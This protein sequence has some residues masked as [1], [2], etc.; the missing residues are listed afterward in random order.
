[1]PGRFPCGEIYGKRRRF[2]AVSEYSS[3]A[4]HERDIDDD[5]ARIPE[6]SVVAARRVARALIEPHLHVGEQLI[7]TRPHGEGGARRLPIASP[8]D[9]NDRV[10]ADDD[11]N[12]LRRLLGQKQSRRNSNS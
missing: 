8:H 7:D 5:R 11:A 12:L 10:L 3:S 9:R 4:A 2:R 6:R 1:M